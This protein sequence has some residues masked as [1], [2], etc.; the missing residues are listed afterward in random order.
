[1]VTRTPT[2]PVLSFILLSDVVKVQ[3]VPAQVMKTQWEMEL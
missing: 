1:M 2:L 3:I